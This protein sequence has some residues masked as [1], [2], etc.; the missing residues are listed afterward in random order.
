M[1]D[2]KVNKCRDCQV[3]DAEIVWLWDCV[4]RMRR[5]LEYIQRE[6]KDWRVRDSISSALSGL[7]GN[8]RYGKDKSGHQ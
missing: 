5:V 3:K 2:A 4:E 7:S 8:V 6:D 1:D